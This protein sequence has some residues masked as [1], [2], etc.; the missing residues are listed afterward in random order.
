MKEIDIFRDIAARLDKYG[1]NIL[2]DLL[3]LYKFTPCEFP[4]ICK[5]KRFYIMFENGRAI[6]RRLDEWNGRTKFGE[7]LKAARLRLG[8]SVEEV[9]ERADFTPSTVL[10]METGGFSYSIDQAARL[11]SVLGCEVTITPH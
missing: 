1:I 4:T 2:P 6:V 8:L 9:A 10:R 5:G 3:E 11:A 7:S